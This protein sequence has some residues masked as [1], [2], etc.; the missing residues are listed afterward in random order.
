MKMLA[1]ATKQA[2]YCKDREQAFFSESPSQKLRTRPQSNG[3]CITRSEMQPA[4]CRFTRYMPGRSAHGPHHSRGASRSGSLPVI[5]A[6]GLAL[7]KTMLPKNII[8]LSYSQ[9]HIN[10]FLCRRQRCTSSVSFLAVIAAESRLATI[11]SHCKRIRKRM[12]NTVQRTQYV[13]DQCVGTL[14][15]WDLALR[16]RDNISR[17]RLHV[18]STVVRL[19]NEKQSYV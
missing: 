3:T 15:I 6:R 13:L 7:S 9:N 16:W 10:M 2:I 11:L 1:T 8:N 4:S 5:L 19:A 12:L 18:R 17:K 14:H